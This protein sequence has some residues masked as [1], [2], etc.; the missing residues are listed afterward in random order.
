M[1]T[2]ASSED[3]ARVGVTGPAT[4]LTAP[5]LAAAPTEGLTLT[6][7]PQPDVVAGEAA[8]RDGDL[9]ALVG[10]DP[11]RPRVF[12]ESEPEA[13]LER[14]IGSD[15]LDHLTQQTGLS[16]AALLSRLSRELPSA[17]DLY[18]TDGRRPA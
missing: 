1:A 18:A 10:G 3:S 16:R 9:D 11:L 5:L 15:T 14:A 6:V 4:A 7:V 12:V 2:I 8:V 17:I 13:D